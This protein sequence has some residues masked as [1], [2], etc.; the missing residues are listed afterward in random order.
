MK[1]IVRTVWIGALSGL[2]FLTACN[3]P[4]GLSRQERKQLIKERDHIQ[5]ILKAR[6]SSCVY[7]SPEILDRYSAQTYRLMNQ[8]DSINAKLGQDVDLAKSARRVEL[9][10]RIA[11]LRAVIREREGSCV[12]GSPEVIE[13]Y[14]RE[15]NRLRTEEAQA[16]KELR[17]LNQ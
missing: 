16:V 1:K 4:K 17:E 5:E 6:E 2:A 12:Y 13:E 7:G 15:T 11:E 10:E 14:S 8:L 3:G 9:Q